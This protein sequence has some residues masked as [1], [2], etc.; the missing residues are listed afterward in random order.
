MEEELI[1]SFLSLVPDVEPDRDYHLGKDEEGCGAG[2]VFTNKQVNKDESLFSRMMMQREREKEKAF[3]EKGLC[4]TCK[5]KL[6]PARRGEICGPCCFADKRCLWCEKYCGEDTSKV[7][8]MKTGKAYFH[9]SKC[10]NEFS[11]HFQICKGCFSESLTDLNHGTLCIKCCFKKRLCRWCKVKIPD[12]GVGVGR[13]FAKGPDRPQV[14]LH[15]ESCVSKYF[16][17]IRACFFC[18][19]DLAEWEGSAC[20][21]CCFQHDLC[22][23]CKVSINNGEKYTTLRFPNGDVVH[24]HY[25]SCAQ[26]YYSVRQLCIWKGCTQWRPADQVYCTGHKCNIPY[27]TKSR[28]DGIGHCYE[29]LHY[30]VSPSM[31]GF[32]LV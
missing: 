23:W 4:K 20:A 22:R 7:H 32:K 25:G 10:L 27:C 21:T 3:E 31:P 18:L 11:L 29:H 15:S 13:F 19:K 1:G 12:D 6:P 26:S 24:L 28:E 9:E 30:V 16:S 2:G 17:Y 5:K 14:Y 8:D